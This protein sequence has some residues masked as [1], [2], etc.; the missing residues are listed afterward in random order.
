MQFRNA[1]LAIAAALLCA[2]AAQAQYEELGEIGYSDGI[3]MQEGMDEGAPQLADGEQPAKPGPRTQRLMAMSFD[4]RPSAILAA[5]SKRE[6]DSKSGGAG[7][8]T[9]GEVKTGDVNIA[10]EALAATKGAA[11]SVGFSSVRVISVQ[12]QPAQV[13]VTTPTSSTAT[14]VPATGSTVVAGT[15]VAV[16]LSSLQATGSAPAVAGS[17]PAAATTTGAAG[18]AQP[19]AEAT[20]EE[21]KAAEAA[22][23]EAA[24]K[25]AEEA[26]KQAEEAKAID[27]ELKKFQRDVTLGDWAAVKAA[28]AGWAKDE[29]KAAYDTLLRSLQEGP[30]QR[31][32]VPQQGQQH[33]ERNQFSPADVLG[34]AAAA[35]HAPSDANLQHLG[36]ILKQALDQGHQ[37]SSFLA[38]VQA[39]IDDAEF[40]VDRRRVAR[41]LVGAGQSE[42]I[43]PFLPTAEVA[44]KEN[45]REGLNL[46]A[47]FC[48]AKNVKD[49]GTKW[50]ERA[51]Q[52]TQ[53]V[54]AVDDLPAAVKNEAITR[55]VEIA[56]KLRAELG[57]AWLDESF[58]S[59][60][61]RGMEIL[62]AIGSAASSALSTT[63]MDLDRREKLLEL[64]ST[65]TKALLR[66]AP[67]LAKGWQ[68]QLSLLAGNWLREA[69]WTYATDNSTSL[70]PRMQRDVYGNFYYYDYDEEGG[71]NQRGMRAEP[72]KTGRVLES[73]P[74]DE[75]I[76][77]VE[78][79]LQPRLRMCYAQ[80]Y[81]KVG[82]PE[83]AFPY[84]EALAA[85]DKVPAKSLV[86]EFLR[87][88][89]QKNNP[90]ANQG[91]SNPY[92]YMYG[93]DQRSNSIP[94]TRSKQERALAE[95][96]KWIARLRAL[97]VEL[98]QKLVASAF[99][100]AHSQ[101]EIYR[102]ETLESVF[103]SVD[104]LAPATLAE[105]V[106]TM[107]TNLVTIW[108]DPAL[109]DDKKT[110]R[111]KADIEAEVLRGYGLAHQT[112]DR[113]LEKHPTSWELALVQASIEHDENQFRYELKKDSQYSGRRTKSFE[114]F[115]RAAQLYADALPGLESGKQSSAV[116]ETWFYAA[117]G[118]CDLNKIDARTQLASSEIPRIKAALE[119]LPGDRSARHVEMFGNALT[120]RIGSCNP[121]VKSRYVRQ[122]LAITGETK[123]TRDLQALSAYYGDLVTEIQL[124][125]SIE[126]PSDVGHSAPFGLRV[127]LRHTAEIERESGGFS[128][129]LQNQN[130]QNYAYN[131]G[132]PLEDYRDKFDEAVRETLRERF[133]VLSVTFNEPDVRSKPDAQDGWRV[134][135]Y[136]YILLKP[137]GPEVDRIPPLKLDLDFLD[138][139]GYCVLPIESTELLIDSKA[140]KGPVRPYEKLALV[141]TL[142][143]RQAKAGK[144]VLEIKATAE[145]LVPTL[146]E[147]ATLAPEGFVEASR[148]EREVAITKFDED[149]EGVLSERLWTI[150]FTGREGLE[151]LPDEFTF[152][153]PKGEVASAEHFRYVDADLAAVGPKVELEYDY[154]EKRST[155][156]WIVGGA[157]A[158][159]AAAFVALR[160]RKSDVETV[161][162]RSRIPDPLTPF[163]L[164]AFLREIEA[165]AKLSPE[166]KRELQAEIAG[167]ERAFF[168]DGGDAQ[169][170]DLVAAARKWAP[171]A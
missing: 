162:T 77:F 132:R 161:A 82:E 24:A 25:A 152:A 4:R 100:A 56:P 28:M 15:A 20:P 124:R 79:T 61:E 81:L 35:P 30:R 117:L 118:A 145:G 138:T 57:G 9:S 58:T 99:R 66:A 146:D 128:K 7:E 166:R 106:G 27:A 154:G 5:W 114:T 46:I 127:D 144:L 116:F 92:I 71:W 47:R 74:T 38:H 10:E 137:R 108:R 168:G 86:D 134:T 98:D 103:G 113:A 123:I 121:A 62:A 157:L 41:I 70:G 148:E 85:T 76:S 49:P 37:L 88:W 112:L 65:A 45:D 2:G 52:A 160:G 75:W 140:D 80:L 130:S 142:D 6:E 44:E 18:A 51:W 1:A 34:L 32:Q 136:A 159:G 48:I 126:G 14:L 3:V 139:S 91:R 55:A 164:L 8:S 26:K 115:A 72:I 158:L 96:G 53:A 39:R 40:G 11:S 12:G 22:A 31:P 29:Q 165:D 147:L 17:A 87:V 97:D 36:V 155:W 150:T 43:E 135:P 69:L 68:P 78:S 50:L 171:Q 163:S 54:L 73:R 67:E 104:A 95:L 122:G 23:A 93:F 167:I 19:A 143:E 153:T 156:P 59:R 84:I 64:Q 120:T 129:Y 16:P 33:L 42:H 119:A 110:K 89:A 151:Q 21:A 105:L 101:A 149:G 83:D 102:L 90:N 63:P 109:Q 133:D 13:V 169:R 94:L 131:Y 170:P 111:K 107:R 125:T 141:Q 60:P